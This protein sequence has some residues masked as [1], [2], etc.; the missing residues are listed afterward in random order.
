MKAIAEQ[1]IRATLA[2]LEASRQEAITV[3]ELYI[4]NPTTNYSG[5]VS[6]LVNAMKQISEAE[7]AID[8]LQRNFLIQPEEEDNE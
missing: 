5:A 7:N 2:N 3:V 6:E 4:K 1:L 8:A